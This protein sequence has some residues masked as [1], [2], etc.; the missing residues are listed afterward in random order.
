MK[1]FIAWLLSL[2]RIKQE[3]APAP[4]V[5]PVPPG[6]PPVSD[7]SPKGIDFSKYAG[8]TYYE[9]VVRIGRGL[10]PEEKIAAKA[11]GVIIPDDPKPTGPAPDKTGY[12]LGTGGGMVKVN[13][14]NGGETKTFSFEVS[15]GTKRAIIQFFGAPGQ[16]FET[17]SV[18]VMDQNNKVVVN[19][20]NSPARYVSFVE[21]KSPTPGKYTFLVTVN[22]SGPLGVQ[23]QQS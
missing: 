3:K 2:F 20:V 9:V 10:S 11:A 16:F 4:E 6:Y 8:W 7:P 23:Y 15:A 14:V 17:Y 18:T 19:E 22:N 1:K 13:Q 5:K 12:D 21:I